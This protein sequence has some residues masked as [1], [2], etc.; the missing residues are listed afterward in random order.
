[1][2]ATRVRPLAPED[3]AFFAAARLRAARMQPYLSSA[4]FSLIPVSVPGYGTFGVD[5]WWRVYLDMDRARE[6]GVEATAAVLLHEANHVLRDHHR[7]ADR[8]GVTS[9]TW[10][11]W[12]LAG[13]AAINDDLVADGHPVPDP[14]LPSTMNLEPG[15][16]EETYFRNLRRRDEVGEKVLCGSGAGGAPLEVEL[17]DD[18]ESQVPV[19]DDVDAAAVR[20]GVAHDVTAAQATGVVVSPGLV[21]WA[22]SVLE[23]QVSWRHLL[24]SAV[25]RPLRGVNGRRHPTWAR[26]DRRSDTR[27]DFPHPGT[28]RYRPEVAVV[29]DTSLSMTM[30]RLNTA[31]T[32]LDAILRRCAAEVTVIVCDTAAVAPQRVRRITQVELTGGGGTDLRVGIAAAAEL[33]PTPTVIVVLTDGGTPWPRSAPVGIGIVAVVIGNDCPLPRGAGITAVRVNEP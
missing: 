24:R 20:R 32:E 21:L 13:D 9:A 5:R 10:R 29:V 25:G 23:P 30:R 15:G 17:D 16:L 11:L 4:V 7:R 3:A 1:M 27:P 14:V 8:A 22:Q 26:P 18:T 33:R 6:W 2:T 28:R 19:V 12:N 31:V